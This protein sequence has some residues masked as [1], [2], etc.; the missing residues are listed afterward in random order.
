MF[1][2]KLLRRA[3][4]VTLFFF[5]F[6]TFTA[7]LAAARQQEDDLSKAKRLYQEGDYE[8]SINLLSKFID[9]LKAMVEQKKNVAEA[10]YLLAKIYF[11]VGDDKKVEENL[12]K[13]YE[14]YPSFTKKDETNFGF[15]ERVENARA[16]FL[17]DK[18]AQAR[19]MEQELKKQEKK[20]A[21]V[22]KETKP[23]AEEFNVIEQPKPKKKKKKFPVLLVV[24]GLVVV[25]A[26]VLL[27]GKKKKD[28][29]APEVFD[30]RGQWRLTAAILGETFS[31]LF[32]FTGTLNSGTFT[33]EGGDTGTY[34][35]T[36]R[37]VQFSYDDYLFS[38][39]GSFIDQN[40][41]EG[42][43]ELTTTEG[44]QVTG[45]WHGDR[46]EPVPGRAAS[47]SITTTAGNP[48]FSKKSIKK[49]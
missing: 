49:K 29:P 15:K 46:Q 33:D 16:A 40:R 35:V 28:E 45:N 25:A 11:E 2:C 37:N 32:N 47:M 23:E 12:E 17:K 3:A 4:L 24:G 30:I 6:F 41:M 7:D 48:F 27:L 14:T 36:G 21:E 5:A 31:G 9:K 1:E 43:F 19:Q 42:N 13:V 26:L 10:F 44:A 34:T 8:S 39:S 18:E 20:E 38:F 22:K